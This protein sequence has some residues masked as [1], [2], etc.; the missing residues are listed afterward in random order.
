[1]K[2]RVYNRF[3]DLLFE[4]D[5]YQSLQF[6]RSHH[7]IS[8]F[9]LHVNRY[10]NG[11]EHL[12][13][14]NLIALDK[15]SNKVGIIQ[16]KEI[17]LDESGKES[18]NFKLTGYS[19]DGLLGRRI[20]HPP[21]D[22]SHDR[23]SGSAEE[24]MKHYVYNNF[25]NTTDE[26]IMPYFVIADNQGR[27][28]HVKHESRYKTVSDELES[29]SKKTGLGWTVYADFRNKELIFDVIETK[30]LTQGNRQ[31]NNP[32]FFSP[33]FE[34]I[35]SQEFIDSDQEL[36]NVGYVGGQGEGVER[37]IVEIGDV[38]GWD[39]IETFVDA[40]DVGDTTEDDDGEEVEL[41]E[42]EEEELLIERGK[43]KMSEMETTFTL[44][45]EI[46]T[47]VTQKTYE[48]VHQGY[49]H[50]GQPV[51]HLRPKV[52]AVTP[53]EY[54]KDFDLGD[55]VDV[56][57]KSWNLT[58]TAP[59][60]EIVEIYESSGFRIDATFGRNRPTLI[61]K[62]QDKF[63]ELEGIEKQEAPERV[64]VS[65]S[66]A[67]KEYTEKK[68]E[69]DRKYTDEQDEVY[70]KKA[71]EFTAEKT[72]ETLKEAI[73]E[74]VRQ[75]ELVRQDAQAYA[76]RAEENAK[77]E[78]VAR[79]EYNERVEEI[80]QDISNQEKVVGDLKD[81]VS[82]AVESI[83]DKVD[84]EWV[85]GQLQSKADR[86][87]VYS[88]EET[89]GMFDNVVSVTKYETDKDGIIKDLNEQSTRLEQTEKDISSKV[90]GTTYKQDKDSLETEIS[91]NKSSINQNKEEIARKVSD[92]QY[93]ADKD[94]ILKDISDNK[95]QI[96]Q[97]AEKVDSKV[98][99]SYVEGELG[100]LD[101]DIQG[102]ITSVRDY[103]SEVEQTA[104]G[105]R[106]DVDSMEKEVN[107]NTEEVK[108]AHSSINQN[109]EAIEERVKTT[110]F[111]EATERITDA[112]GELITLAGEVSAKASKKEFDN[113]EGRV[114]EAEG[115]LEVLPGE[116]N[117]KVSKDGV[118]GSINATPEELLIDFGRLKMEGA[119][120]ARH[121]RSLN[122][123]NVG[124]QFIV[125]SSGNVTFKGNMTGATGT[126]SGEMRMRDL[127]IDN[128][129]LEQEGASSIKLQLSTPRH[130]TEIPFEKVGY[131]IFYSYDGGLK[132][133]HESLNGEIEKLDHFHVDSRTM[134]FDGK[135]QV[136]HSGLGGSEYGIELPQYHSIAASPNDGHF[137]IYGNRARG[138]RPFTVRSH[139]DTQSGVGNNSYRDDLILASN[140]NFQVPGVRNNTT[141]ASANVNVSA[142]GWLR[143]STSA[144]K[145][146]VLEEPMK[147]NPYRIHDV[148]PKSWFDRFEV[149]NLA[150]AM[151]CEYRGI[152]ADEDMEVIGAKRVYGLVAEDVVDAGLEMYVNYENGEVEGIQYD[153]LWTLL[154]PISKDH[155]LKLDNHEIKLTKQEKKIITLEDKVETLEENVKT[156][157]KEINNLKGVA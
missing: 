128:P 39:R 2:I 85:D 92:S 93:K 4:I 65:Y 111:N 151:D 21:S 44:E 71:Q 86:D 102:E 45:A 117:A 138:Q 51:D 121:I 95:S 131:V 1:M 64:S 141:T 54:E 74:A 69:E 68:S 148:V 8:S 32:V 153:R 30:D 52:Q 103:A 106:T 98:D 91:N 56:V 77:S 137:S 25:I 62:L 101:E 123:L 127:I 139:V 84:A 15:Q 87:S 132:I 73:D 35:K 40:R 82:E 55:R 58:M 149:E 83:S 143:Y 75:D 17:A 109:S 80:R 67:N 122:G 126:F 34:T 48:R 78:S 43:D 118:I 26:R 60:T 31:G 3:L 130:Q 9:E 10:I 115:K 29:I 150:E 88:K 72:S 5:R 23:K 147:T 140:G 57:N 144:R 22:T 46:L 107:D 16:S 94:G 59:I 66:K 114:T 36:R 108:K 155:E 129:N 136:G 105:I 125:D 41:T 97:T 19:L 61:T 6:K 42:E 38:E 135:I 37:K 50:P 154:I 27:G 70:D 53:F 12:Q 142:S 7:G 90:D 146:K 81:D 63:D 47:P 133:S 120:E 49:R 116:I 28:E 134:I 11:A 113:V 89:D 79:E 152:K 156:M 13:K 24:V 104:K 110:D 76:N 20:T 119:L 100:K 14:G 124:D 33:E 145:Y 99:A 18:E 96:T 157:E 112:E